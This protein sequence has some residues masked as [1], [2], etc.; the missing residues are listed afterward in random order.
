MKIQKIWTEIVYTGGGAN[1]WNYWYYVTYT[2]KGNYNGWNSDAG[3]T[4]VGQFLDSGAGSGSGALKKLNKWME[5]NDKCK[6][7][8]IWT[9]NIHIGNGAQGWYYWYL[10]AFTRK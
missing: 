6:I 2:E 10:F 9:H 4:E 3:D 5:S 1:G 7:Q 8:F